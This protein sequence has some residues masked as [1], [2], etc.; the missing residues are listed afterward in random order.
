MHICICVFCIYPY[1]FSG[2]VRAE[3]VPKIMQAASRPAY[4]RYATDEARKGLGSAK[5]ELTS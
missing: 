3:T 1:S 4:C 5:E 2:Q